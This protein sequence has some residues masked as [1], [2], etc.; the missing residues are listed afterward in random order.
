MAGLLAGPVWTT[1]T[2][3]RRAGG[4]QWPGREKQQQEQLGLARRKLEKVDKDEDFCPGLSHKPG[5]KVHLLSRVL[6]TPGTKDLVPA[7]GRLI[8]RTGTKGPLQQKPGA[9]TVVPGPFV[10]VLATCWD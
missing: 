2:G 9:V 5:Q 3:D 7:G 8:A 10:P 6:A 1:G 4:W